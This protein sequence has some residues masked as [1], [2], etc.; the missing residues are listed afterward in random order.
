MFVPRVSGNTMP[1]FYFLFVKRVVLSE[2][3]SVHEVGVKW[4]I[5]SLVIMLPLLRQ[6]VSIG[7]FFSLF[8]N[9]FF[10]FIDLKLS[11]HLTLPV[12]DI[13]RLMFPRVPNLGSGDFVFQIAC[14]L[15][16]HLFL[17]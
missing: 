4:G 7:Y 3:I 1:E 13:S 8:F 16:V 17:R 15:F 11:S 14:S 6:T 5:C 12:R 10:R 9:K 2:F